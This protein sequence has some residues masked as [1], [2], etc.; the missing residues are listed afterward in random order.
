[1]SGEGERK[2]RER[3]LEREVGVED[4]LLEERME[5]AEVAAKDGEGDLLRAIES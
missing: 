1:M 4:R 5:V 3:M 2:E